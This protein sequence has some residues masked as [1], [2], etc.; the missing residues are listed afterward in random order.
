MTVLP[1]VLKIWRNL[2]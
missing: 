1:A 2:L